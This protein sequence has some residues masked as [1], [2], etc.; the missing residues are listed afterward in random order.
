MLKKIKIIL[1]NTIYIAYIYISNIENLP[2]ECSQNK[3]RKK[4]KKIGHYEE[5]MSHGQ[6]RRKESDKMLLLGETEL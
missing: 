1:I 6:S 4:L 3:T 2:L 5:R